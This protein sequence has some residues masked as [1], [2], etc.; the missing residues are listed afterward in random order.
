MQR[1]IGLWC[2]VVRGKDAIDHGPL[3]ISK[4]SFKQLEVTSQ[5]YVY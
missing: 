1:G 3:Q 4:C 2:H 5:S